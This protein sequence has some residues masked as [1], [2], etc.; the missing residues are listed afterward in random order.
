M[1][2]FPIAIIHLQ[3]DHFRATGAQLSLPQVSSSRALVFVERGVLSTSAWRAVVGGC[4]T[5]QDFEEYLKVG[6]LAAII[7]RPSSILE[8]DRSVRSFMEKMRGRG[9]GREGLTTRILGDS[10]DCFSIRIS[11]RFV[12]RNEVYKLTKSRPE[13]KRMQPGK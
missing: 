13:Q 2:H 1:P 3:R 7:L 8:I 12:H 6:A 5:Q 11:A 10:G 9:R 4:F